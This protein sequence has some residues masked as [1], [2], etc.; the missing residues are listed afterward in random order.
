MAVVVRV[1]LVLLVWGVV[2]AEEAVGVGVKS[3]AARKLA[4]TAPTVPRR[5]R[6]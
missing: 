6:R 4:L 3:K 2:V 5:P 1:L